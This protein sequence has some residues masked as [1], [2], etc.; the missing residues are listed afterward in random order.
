MWRT[1]T[2]SRRLLFG[3]AVGLFAALVVLTVR[4]VAAAISG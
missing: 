4:Y 1:L 3:I 2:K